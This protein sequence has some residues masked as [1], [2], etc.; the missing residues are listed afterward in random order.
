M[1]EILDGKGI[2]SHCYSLLT[3]M[4]WKLRH[5]DN[6]WPFIKRNGFFIDKL[7]FFFNALVHCF[8]L[9][10]SSDESKGPFPSS[11]L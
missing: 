4:F 2:A 10:A 7:V 6:N 9:T 8:A 5:R 3:F 1:G 11:C